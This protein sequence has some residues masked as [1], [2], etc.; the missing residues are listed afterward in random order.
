MPLLHS[1]GYP[2]YMMYIDLAEIDEVFAGRWFWSTK[3]IALARFKR[4][5]YFGDKDESIDQ[6]IRRLVADKTG[7]KPLGRVCLLTNLSCFGYCFNPIS[8]Y[9]C[10]DE[11]DQHIE[12]IVAEVSNT[13]WG[14]RRCYVLSADA[15]GESPGNL[16]T[17]CEKELHVSPFMGMDATYEWLLTMP[18]EKLVVRIRNR[19]DG[20]SLFLATLVLKREEI[21]GISLAKTLCRFPFMTFRLVLGIYWQAFRLWTKGVPIHTHPD[22]DTSIQVSQ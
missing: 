18:E 12:A 2:V 22:K 19:T 7:H 6:S 13:P 20:E 14:E 5:N 3:R 1:F 21:S 17:E 16:R 10:F 11:S 9:Y 4:E 15:A 8:L